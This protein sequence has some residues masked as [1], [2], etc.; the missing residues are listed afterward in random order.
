MKPFP[1]FRSRLSLKEDTAAPGGAGESSRKQMSSVEVCGK[2]ISYWMGAKPNPDREGD[3]LL[4]IHGAGGGQFSWVYQKAP[5]EKRYRPVIIELPGHGASE[6]DGE[7]QIGCYADHVHS[8]ADRLGLSNVYVIGHS[9]GGA[10]AQILALRRAGFV[11]GIV[12]AGTGA[13]LKV[14]PRILTGIKERF[15]ETVQEIT[16]FAYSRNAPAEFVK[17]GIEQLLE[18]GPEVLYRDFVACD[19]FDV[20]KEVGA[21]EVP[22]LVIC[23][24]E[25]ELTPVKYSEFLHDRMKRSRLEIIRGAGHM[26][27]MERPDAFN[28]KIMDFLKGGAFSET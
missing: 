10:I 4:F 5:F 21:L 17:R 22:A 24:D 23:G 2:A 28:E 7:D 15:R 8:F 6:G 12:L 27:M 16:R 1:M 13:R 26:V 19:R 3:T 14:I 9:M 18:C 11:K 25:D 20:R